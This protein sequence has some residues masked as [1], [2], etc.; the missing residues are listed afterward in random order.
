MCLWGGEIENVFDLVIREETLEVQNQYIYR[1]S[2][3]IH[4]LY[5]SKQWEIMWG[6]W[7][8]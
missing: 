1:L 2:H 4:M 8:N 5:I 7:H 3:V 6:G